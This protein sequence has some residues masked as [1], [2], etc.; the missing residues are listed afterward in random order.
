MILCLGTTPTAQRT[1]IFERVT[2]DAVNRAA[3]VHEHAS[4]KS[5]NVARVAHCLGEPVFATGFLGGDRGAFIRGELDRAGIDHDFVSVSPQTRLCTTVVDRS[6]KTAT[7]L[8]EESA[9]VTSANW[10]Q[11]FQVFCAAVGRARLCVLSGSLP[12][13]GP[14]GF[15][16]DCVRV[17]ASARCP[18]VL[19]ARGE[20]LRLAMSSAGLTIKLNREELAATVGGDLTDDESLRTA[21]RQ[22]APPGGAA[23]VTLGTAGAV[24]FDGCSFCRIGSPCVETVSAVGSGDAFAA[25]FAVG[26]VRDKSFRHACALGAACGAANAMTPLSG[27][28]DP[29]RIPT[30]L[31]TAVVTDW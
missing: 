4:G 2:P 23:I 11:L 26:I 13:G 3:E 30:L 21:M 5:V 22:A 10:A 31:E 29:R 20:P 19:D 25:G 15:Y 14:I 12:P 24:A 16:A 1:L 27:Q 18:V 17:A 8:V 6:K 28:I 9:A 7:E